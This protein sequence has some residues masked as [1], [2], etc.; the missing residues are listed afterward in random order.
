MRFS[1]GYVKR[2]VQDSLI[3]AKGILFRKTGRASRNI[4]AGLVRTEA[5]EQRVGVREAVVHPDIKLRF[6][7]LANRRVGKV[8]TGAACNI[9]FREQ[10]HH[11]LANGVDQ[12][13]GMRRVVKRVRSRNLVAC[14]PLGLASVRVYWQRV[15]A[16]IA[17]EINI[18]M[19]VGVCRRS[20]HVRVHNNNAGNGIAK[21]VSGI[22]TAAHCLRGNQARE[23][24]PV[25]LKL[26]L[27]IEKE[28]GLVLSDRPAHRPAKLVQVEFLPRWGE[29]ASGIEVG[30]AQELV[31]TAV[32]VIGSRLRR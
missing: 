16:W 29:E 18:R 14:G 25:T 27:A 13:V 1:N 2:V 32:E 22:I 19:C 30:V 15:A 12:T 5:G 6:V 10:V 4:R 3:A 24:N 11:G 7:Q 23:S 28:K 26:L 21:R 17:L 8:K 31:Q 9:G 20:D